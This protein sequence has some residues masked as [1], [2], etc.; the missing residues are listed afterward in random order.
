MKRYLLV[1]GALAF[2]AGGCS[3]SSDDPTEQDP[4]QEQQGVKLVNIKEGNDVRPDWAYPNFNNYEQTMTVEVRIQDEL[5]PYA[6]QE[7]LLCATI[8]GEIRGLTTPNLVE[9]VW[10]F[11]ITVGSNENAQN[12]ILSYYCDKL[13][14]IFTAEW[15]T[16]DPTLSPTGEGGLYEPVFAIPELTDQ[17]NK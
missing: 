5:Q 2:V 9:D 13:H 14:R 15:T 10:S 7:D 1:L 8:N 6:S 3:K 11:P 4:N 17:K 12:I 16:F